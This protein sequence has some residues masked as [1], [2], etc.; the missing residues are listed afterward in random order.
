VLEGTFDLF[1]VEIKFGFMAKTRR[2]ISLKKFI[3][4]N[5]WPFC[6]VINQSETA[7][8]ITPEIYQLA[9]GWL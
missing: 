5:N 8:W 3:E 2:L 1:A 9:V 4:E 7:E 6:L